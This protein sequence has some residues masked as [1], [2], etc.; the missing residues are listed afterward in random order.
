MRR[1]PTVRV[2][3]TRCGR[4]ARRRR[5]EALRGSCGS[6]GHPVGAI[7]PLTGELLAPHELLPEDSRY[8]RVDWS[9]QTAGGD[10]VGYEEWVERQYESARA[11]RE[12]ARG[13]HRDRSVETLPD[14][15]RVLHANCRYVGCCVEPDLTVPRCKP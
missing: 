4:T 12:A 6:C 11:A 15:P 10:A 8:T 1:S 14:A 9:R 2:Q 3:C 7:H 5:R 13:R